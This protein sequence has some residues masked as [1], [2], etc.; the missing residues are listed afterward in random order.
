ME[1][2]LGLGMRLPFLSA[3]GNNTL[4]VTGKDSRLFHFSTTQNA[5]QCPPYDCH[6]V[7][8]GW[9]ALSLI[10][11]NPGARALLKHTPAFASLKLPRRR[12]Q[13]QMQAKAPSLFI[14]TVPNGRNVR[15]WQLWNQAYHRYSF[16]ELTSASVWW[17]SVELHS[18]CSKLLTTTIEI[19][20]DVQTLPIQSTEPCSMGPVGK[21]AL[22]SACSASGNCHLS[23]I[24]LPYSGRNLLQWFSSTTSCWQGVTLWLALEE[25]L[26]GAFLL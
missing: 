9:E 14:I 21:S 12:S 11:K 1:E 13:E 2:V 7:E 8:E 23:Q 26:S 5:A 10:S 16:P 25:A 15:A 18:L 17:V 24:S 19:W 3:C 20:E 4:V 6:R 22:S